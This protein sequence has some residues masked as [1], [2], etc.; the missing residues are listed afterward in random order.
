MPYGMEITRHI[1]AIPLRKRPTIDTAF[2]HRSIR[3]YVLY[4]HI[5][6]YY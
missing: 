4:I 1:L 5:Y 3:T 2:R 6:E